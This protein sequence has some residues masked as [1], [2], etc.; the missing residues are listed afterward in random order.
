MTLSGKQ[1][2]QNSLPTPLEVVDENLKD[3]EQG[4]TNEEEASKS[5]TKEFE[6]IIIRPCDYAHLTPPLFLRALRGRK[7]KYNYSHI[8]EVLKQVKVNIPLLDMIKQVPT[9]AKLLKDLCTMKRG[10]NIKKKAILTKQVSAII[11]NKIP[12]KHKDPGCPTISVTIG[13]T[14]VEKALLDLGASVNILFYLV[15]KQFGLRE[16]KPTN[17]TLSLTNKSIKKSRGI[18]E[19]VLV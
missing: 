4:K 6:R 14:H 15:Y 13:E 5:Q 19:D 11:E 7:K 9:Y 8:L 17:I 12:I 1:I 2:Q 18:V 10:L 16:L 3:E